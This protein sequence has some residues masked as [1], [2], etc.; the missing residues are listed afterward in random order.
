M[1]RPLA[2]AAAL[3]P[4]SE[5]QTGA[6]AGPAG[7]LDV[8][9]WR[10]CRSRHVWTKLFDQRLLGILQAVRQVL[11]QE[12][13]RARAGEPLQLEGHWHCFLVC[14]GAGDS[15]IALSACYAA[16]GQFIA[17]AQQ[18]A[19]AAMVCGG[20]NLASGPVG[21][22]TS[23]AAR[24]SGLTVM[25]TA[26]SQQESPRLSGASPPAAGLGG[27]EGPQ[28]G[29]A[30]CLRPRGGMPRGGGD[31]PAPVRLSRRMAGRSPEMHVPRA[32]EGNAWAAIGAA[33]HAAVAAPQLAAPQPIAPPLLLPPMEPA[34]DEAVPFDA[35]MLFGDA[36]GGD[37]LYFGVLAEAAAAE[38]AAAE[39]EAA[40]AA[41]VQQLFDE[42]ANEE[43]HNE[44]GIQ[45]AALNI[46]ADDAA[47]PVHRR[48]CAICLERLDNAACGPM[49][50]LPCHVPGT[51]G[52]HA[53]HGACLASSWNA[54]RQHRNRC[55]GC[56]AHQPAEQL[57]IANAAKASLEARAVDDV[58]LQAERDA[59]Q[60]WDNAPP[61]DDRPSL[62]DAPLPGPRVAGEWHAIDKR[63]V[64]DCVVS[65][66]GHIQD[67]P[68]ELRVDWACANVD[69]FRQ[70]SS[71]Q[72][73]GDG[74]ALERSLKWFLCLHSILL[75]GPRRGTRGS[76]RAR[77]TSELSLR[78]QAW[79]QGERK[80]LVD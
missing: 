6:V 70:I 29:G 19:A 64:F 35:A 74:V 69:V 31:A 33:R 39:L 58:R 44:L 2:D 40:Y 16:A 22:A 48:D 46:P 49:Q 8:L 65:P 26:A 57:A 43:R 73:A 72:Q 56:R 60:A 52:T 75:R 36:E 13:R 5:G 79:R 59:Q 76:G 34:L 10:L 47:V 78:F 23:G 21:E 63:S 15:K 27:G 77:T 67:V 11:W 41:L 20:G 61:A 30:R 28:L 14:I 18:A 9:W 71:A 17:C 80:S 7:P 12:L 38:A 45:A 51:T 50:V 4:A 25:A 55:P 37:E 66:C 62:E 1:R 42:V 32:S 24:A 53:Y 54:D 3:V 68:E